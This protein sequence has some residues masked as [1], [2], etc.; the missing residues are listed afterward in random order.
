MQTSP[1]SAY[2]ELARKLHPDKG[3]SDQDFVCL[4]ALYNNLQAYGKQLVAAQQ[5][6]SNAQAE[7]ARLCAEAASAEETYRSPPQRKDL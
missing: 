2:H 5:T 4:N 3:G 1:K 6:A 7:I